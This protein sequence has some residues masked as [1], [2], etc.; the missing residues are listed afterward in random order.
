MSGLDEFGEIARLFRP[1]T[2]GAAGA[3]DLMDDAAVI[4]PRPGHDLVATKDAIVEGVHM[5]VGEAPGLAGRKLARVNTID[6]TSRSPA[7]VAEEVLAL[8]L[9]SGG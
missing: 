1:L 4:S 8:W 5:P 6:T 9:R 7:D 2:R 3:L